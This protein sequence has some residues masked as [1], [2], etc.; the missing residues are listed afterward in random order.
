MPLPAELPLFCESCG[1]SLHALPPRRCGH[2]T[3]LHFRCPECGHQQPL[4]TI[5]PAVH[6]MLSRIRLAGLLLWVFFKLNFFGWLLF[7]W[8][9]MGAEWSFRYDWSSRASNQ[10]RSTAPP[11]IAR[12]VDLEAFLAF[13][14]FAF[15]F[16]LIG[17]MLLLRWRSSALVGVSLSA[18]VCVAIYAGI[19]FTVWERQLKAPAMSVDWA[20]MMGVTAAGIMLGC[21]LIWPIW[22]GLVKLFL[23]AR[24]SEVLLGRQTGSGTGRAA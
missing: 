9:A 15:A 11:F 1:Y 17:R 4:M 18:L 5:R 7:A 3:L 2:C 14:L 6:K 16:G 24:A 21:V 10:A 19:R 13:S 8:A 23:P 20:V 12:E 22:A